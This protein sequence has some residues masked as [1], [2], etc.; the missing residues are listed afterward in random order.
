MEKRPNFSEEIFAVF[1][2]T[3]CR[4]LWPQLYWLM[5]H[6]QTVSYG[7]IGI[8]YSGRLILLYNNH[9]EGRQT[10]ENNLVHIGT[11]R[12]HIMT[13]SISTFSSFFMTFIFMKAGL[14]TKIAKICTQQKFVAIITH[15][16]VQ[17]L[18]VQA[19]SCD[20]YVYIS[21]LVPRPSPSFLSLAVR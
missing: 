10:V 8:L 15:C 21:S 17:Q 4:T 16:T 11:W 14:S 7:F 18:H 2:F 1:L 13:S 3:E 6:L 5:Q 9:L 19:Q 12:T 20:M